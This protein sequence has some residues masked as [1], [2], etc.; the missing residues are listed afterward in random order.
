MSSWNVE[1]YFVTIISGG[2][3]WIGSMIS[4]QNKGYST[5]RQIR[6]K[7]DVI[8]K[9]RKITFFL[10][11]ICMGCALGEWINGG[12][13]LLFL[14]ME[15]GID[16]K[17]EVNGIISGIHYGT[18]FLPYVAVMSMYSY[19]SSIKKRK[20]DLFIIFS[21][22]IISI[23]FHISRGELLIYI[24]SYSFIY[25]RYNRVKFKHIIGFMILFIAVFVGGMILRI[26]NKESIA[27]TIM[28][29]RY[30]SIF[31]SYIATCY[32]NLNDLIQSDIPYHLLGDAT[33]APLWTITG[34][35]DLTE[36][37]LFDQLG[38][39]NATTYLYS[40]YHDFKIAGIIFFPFLI[41]WM[42]S[43][44]YRQTQK[45]SSYWILLLSAMQKAIFT[46]F[47]GN[48]FFGELVILFPYLL[49]TIII[50]I[51][52]TATQRKYYLSHAKI[53]VNQH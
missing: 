15:E 9:Y 44:L 1:M 38:V 42:L 53:F 35:E 49:I 45:K 46:S 31:Y 52:L 8:P 19:I 29:N 50:L 22:I 16:L 37:T 25:T 30:Y 51:L 28:D 43:F 2:A 26:N 41:G 3:F 48:Y 24:L 40:F 23:F 32:A 36:V 4:T 5:K 20:I 14:N 47:F 10:F 7:K 12:M 6:E 18:I 13:N 21:S 27:F 33:L 34:M 39:F 17:S 11:L